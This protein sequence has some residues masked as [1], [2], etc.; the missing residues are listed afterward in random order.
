MN[1]YRE[2][3]AVAFFAGMCGALLMVPILYLSQPIERTHM[4]ICLFLGSLITAQTGGGTWALG[5]VLHV[6]AG[7]LIG[8]VYGMVFEWWGSSEWWQGAMLSIPHSLLAGLA[9]WAAGSIHPLMPDIF[10]EPGYLGLSVNGALAFHLFML[11]AVYGATVG[12]IYTVRYEHANYHGFHRP[13]PH[14]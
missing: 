4:D 3:W 10:P 14:A 2:N 5:L 13:L 9:L 6:I 7:G 1:A 12:G 11:N 8:L